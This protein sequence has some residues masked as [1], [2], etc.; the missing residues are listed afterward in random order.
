MTFHRS[1]LPKAIL[2]ALISVVV[3]FL[4]KEFVQ[5]SSAT[6]FISAAKLQSDHY[7]F[8]VF[9]DKGAGETTAYGTS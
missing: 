4:V 7:Y 8:L 2:V 1:A 6:V 5:R 9:R 3:E